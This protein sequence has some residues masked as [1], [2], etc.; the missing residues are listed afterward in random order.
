[1]PKEAKMECIKGHNDSSHFEYQS[2][3]DVISLINIAAY[4]DHFDILNYLI[5]VFTKVMV[6]T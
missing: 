2:K 5:R 3:D 1:M 6:D 4:H